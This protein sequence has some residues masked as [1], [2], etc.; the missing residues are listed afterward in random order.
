[1][2]CRT[3]PLRNAE[4]FLGFLADNQLLRATQSPIMACVRWVGHGIGHLD[5]RGVLVRRPG[6]HGETAASTHERRLPLE[7]RESGTDSIHLPI[8]LKVLDHP[9]AACPHCSC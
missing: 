2:R 3:S 8:V 7:W 9:P 1:V 5:A 4:S 6:Y